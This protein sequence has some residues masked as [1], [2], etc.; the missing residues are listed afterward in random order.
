MLHDLRRDLHLQY[1]LTAMNGGNPWFT[2]D[3][4]TW[5]ERPDAISENPSELE[6]V[7]R[8][9]LPLRKVGT[10]HH[11]HIRD[12][13]NQGVSDVDFYARIHEGWKF[14][15]RSRTVY[16]A[17]YETSGLDDSLVSLSTSFREPNVTSASDV[18]VKR[19][20]F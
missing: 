9:W 13:Y 14:Y 15:I 18:N 2:R 3:E 12:R 4:I 7:F 17:N 8:E 11:R 6:K 20:L 19:T 16:P 1:D 10:K 5:C